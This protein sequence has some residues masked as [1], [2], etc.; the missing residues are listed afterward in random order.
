VCLIDDRLLR[1]GDPGFGEG[2]TRRTLEP[3]FGAVNLPDRP[4]PIDDDGASAFNVLVDRQMSLAVSKAHCHPVNS[5]WSRDRLAR[6]I[7]F[8]LIF[9][10]AE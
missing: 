6:N 8:V 4:D 1:Y 10:S 2:K 7:R 5:S 3:A 9:L